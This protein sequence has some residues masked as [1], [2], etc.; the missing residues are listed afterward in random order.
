MAY[1]NYS[2][3]YNRRHEPKWHDAYIQVR[4]QRIRDTIITIIMIP[5][6]LY[7]VYWVLLRVS[8]EQAMTYRNFFVEVKMAIQSFFNSFS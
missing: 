7:A 2:F 6:V 5:V 3:Y 1:H 4:N 8:P